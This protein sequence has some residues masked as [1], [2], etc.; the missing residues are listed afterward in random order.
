MT[1]LSAEDFVAK[2]IFFVKEVGRDMTQ[3]GSFEQALRDAGIQMFNLVR[4]S[5]IIPSNCKVISLKEGK[6]LL[7]PGEMIF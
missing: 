4:V 5:S 1:R 3:L 7:K 6:R 2:K